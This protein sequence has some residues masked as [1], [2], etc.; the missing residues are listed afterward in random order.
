[1]A[2]FRRFE[3]TPKFAVSGDTTEFVKLP[4]GRYQLEAFLPPRLV[5][6]RRGRIRGEVADRDT[7]QSSASPESLS[8]KCRPMPL[9]APTIKTCRIADSF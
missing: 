7:V 6:Q 9:L 4:L 2:G 1:V 8:A 3:E 5:D